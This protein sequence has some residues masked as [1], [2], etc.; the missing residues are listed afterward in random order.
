VANN[1][2]RGAAPLFGSGGGAVV[3]CPLNIVGGAE[4][5]RTMDG[6]LW[7]NGGRALPAEGCSLAMALRCTSSGPSAKRSVRWC[8][9]A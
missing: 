9:Q 2:L 3:P 5:P 1:L 8:A 6:N 4:R 7:W